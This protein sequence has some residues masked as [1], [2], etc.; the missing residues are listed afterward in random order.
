[1]LLLLRDAPVLTAVV[2]TRIVVASLNE[3]IQP[4]VLPETM[5]AH[6][7]SSNTDAKDT[8]AS[9]AKT[10][11][12]AL[13]RSDSYVTSARSQTSN[14]TSFEAVRPF[15]MD[16]FIDK[17]RYVM[18][19]EV[20]RQVKGLRDVLWAIQRNVEQTTTAGQQIRKKAIAAAVKAARFI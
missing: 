8:S 7:Q 12:S 9:S 14:F 2:S 16:D 11:A 6:S 3:N 15:S 18:R 17:L 1:L 10:T 19:Q 13:S 4:L 20:V 5:G